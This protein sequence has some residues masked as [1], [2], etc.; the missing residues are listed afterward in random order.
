MENSNKVLSPEE[1]T[2]LAELA[3]E[4]AGRVAKQIPVMGAVAWLM[5]QGSGTRHTL[6]SDLQWRVMPPLILDQ[7]KL[8][9]RDNL[10]LAYVS[11]ALLSEPVAERYRGKPHQLAAGDWQSGDQVWVVDLLA[12]YGGSDEVIKDLKEKVFPGRPIFQLIGEG[13]DAVKW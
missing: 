13:G 12:P 5:L 10:P 7:A 9:V 11:W 2:K 1:L 8:F 3:K 4:Q 6:L